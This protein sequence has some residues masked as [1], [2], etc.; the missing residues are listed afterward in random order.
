[1]WA[2]PNSQG[3]KYYIDD[4]FLMFWFR[5]IESNRTM[6]ELGKYELLGETIRK[7]Y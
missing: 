5:F 2:K 7:E 3:V 6:V 4:C 1:M